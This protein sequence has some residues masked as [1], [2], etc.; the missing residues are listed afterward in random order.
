MS[1]GRIFAE[2]SHCRSLS[3]T[4]LSLVMEKF[5]D[6]LSLSQFRSLFPVT[7][8][9]S[10][11]DDA[12]LI[13]VRY[14]ETL[15]VL[16]HP[17]RFDG[18]LAFYCISGHIK[19]TINLS[20]FDVEENS[21]FVYM[22][23]NII[24]V[25]DVDKNT[26]GNMSFRVIA[27]TREYM[28]S[29]DVDIP[30]LMEKRMILQR[31]PYFFIRGVAQSIARN[32]V[33]LAGEVLASNLSYKRK[34]VSL[35][36]SS[37]FSIAVGI[38]EDE[39]YADGQ[40]AVVQGRGRIVADANYVAPVEPTTTEIAEDLIE[41]GWENWTA[42]DKAAADDAYA[43]LNAGSTA[44]KVLA[45]ALKVEIDAYDA[46]IELQD[47]KDAAQA[48]YDKLIDDTAAAATGDD[49]W[50]EGAVEAA[51]AAVAE[52][53]ATMDLDALKALEPEMSDDIWMNVI[54]PVVKKMQAEAAAIATVETYE[55]LTAAIANSKVETI[56][57]ADDITLKNAI[58]LPADM[59]LDG[60]DYT[61]DASQVKTTSAIVIVDGCTVKNLTVEG[62]TRMNSW[63]SNYG[64]QAY[65]D[66]VKATLEDVNVTGF[67]AAILVNGAELT[68]KGTVD[69]SGNE[70]GGIEVSQG[71]GIDEVSKLI[72][73]GTVV[74]ST[75]SDTAPTAWIPCD[76][77][78]GTNAQGSIEGVKWTETMVEKDSGKTFQLWYTIND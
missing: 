11:G 60:A 61:L 19:V 68:L 9:L 12:C 48:G 76:D 22:P 4:K 14:D 47:A 2:S 65:G 62:N 28:E 37:F 31:K 72:V 39:M 75:E 73:E 57:L 59:T 51:K 27:M 30:G 15:S 21:L 13:D 24:C 35:L 42:D 1:K 29:L 5:T 6:T 66:G 69:V 54:V 38:L 64:I 36:L 45:A 74:N 8:C 17:C 41:A 20:E 7:S 40:T 18:F 58:T 53:L 78:K 55:E 16:T 70:F 50:P 43:T 3:G 67:D 25:T 52:K 34:S 49:A 26:A 56:I 44:D 46:A 33:A 77:A 32:Y 23:G 63:D 71:V 10:M